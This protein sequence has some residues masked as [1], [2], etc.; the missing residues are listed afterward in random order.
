M[1]ETSS[2]PHFLWKLLRPKIFFALLYRVE[3]FFNQVVIQILEQIQICFPQEKSVSA[4]S[5]HSPRRWALDLHK[6]QPGLPPFLSVCKGGGS[7]LCL[8][9]PAHKSKGAA[10]RFPRSA[11]VHSHLAP[12]LRLPI[13]PP[14]TI[15]SCFSRSFPLCNAGH[16]SRLPDLKSSSAWWHWP[17]T[18]T[19]WYTHSLLCLSIQLILTMHLSMP[20]IQQWTELSL[21]KKTKNKQIHRYLLCQVVVSAGNGGSVGGREVLLYITQ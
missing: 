1:A 12:L 18:L 20:E 10:C 7:C 4:Y 3:L 11:L 5:M 21:G 19:W 15:S 9:L 16:L 14:F 17:L 2:Q 8:L 6:E 13:L